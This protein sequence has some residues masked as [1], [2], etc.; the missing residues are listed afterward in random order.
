MGSI[1]KIAYVTTV[2]AIGTLGLAFSGMPANASSKICKLD[3]YHHGLGVSQP[4]LRQAKFSAVKA[5]Q[6]FTVWEYGPAWGKFSFSMHGKFKCSQD[7]DRTFKCNVKA[8]PCRSSRNQHAGESTVEQVI[9][10][11]QRR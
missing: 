10:Q 11:F 1:F 7:M 8:K 5:W 3:H 6:K 4:S 9:S 2:F